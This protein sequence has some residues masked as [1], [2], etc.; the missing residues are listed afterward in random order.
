MRRGQNPP[1]PHESAVT[2]VGDARHALDELQLASSDTA[3]A[4]I[5]PDAL[6]TGAKYVADAKVRAGLAVMPRCRHS[7]WIDWPKQEYVR[8]IEAVREVGGDGQ[9][10]ESSGETKEG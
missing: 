4:T 2:L 5:V 6:G 8:S 9:Q 3:A 7:D 10:V 1:S